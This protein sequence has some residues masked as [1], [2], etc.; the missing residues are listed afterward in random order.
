MGGQGG[1][2]NVFGGS[3]G[4]GQQDDDDDRGR[5]QD[6]NADIE[7]LIALIVQTV[8]PDSWADNGGLG[9]I[10]PF[11]NLLVVRNNILVHQALGGYVEE[12]E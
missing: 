4:G 12:S 5:D 10:Q 6:D 1:N 2:Q 11:R 7:E 9:T 3:Q 8:E